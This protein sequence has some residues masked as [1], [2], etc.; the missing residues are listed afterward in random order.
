MATNFSA[1]TEV[2]YYKN[3]SKLHEDWSVFTWFITRTNTQTNKQTNFK[4]S[5]SNEKF[6]IVPEWKRDLSNKEKFIRIKAC[7]Q[8]LLWNIGMT[9]AK[10]WE[11]IVQ[12]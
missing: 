10:I 6:T 8:M 11:K 2:T 4:F 5:H 1:Q 12:N 3:I 7:F 9:Y